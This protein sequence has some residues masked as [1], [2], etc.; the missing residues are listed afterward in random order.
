MLI[1]LCLRA[2]VLA[3]VWPARPIERP[4]SR[5]AAQTPRAGPGARA[6]GNAVLRL[7]A[8]AGNRAVGQ[9]LR[10]PAAEKEDKPSQ[11]GA[12][13]ASSIIHD[14]LQTWYTNTH[15]GLDSAD[16]SGNSDGRKWFIIALAGNLLWA[17]TAFLDPLVLAGAL[18][19]KLMSVSGATIGSGT[20][21]QLFETKPEAGLKGMIVDGLSK[22]RH[23][24][25][26]DTDLIERVDDAFERHGLTDRND[27]KQTV[28]RYEL[29]WKV[30]FGDRVPYGDAAAIEQGAKA[31][32][33]AISAHF[34][35]KYHAL[36]MFVATEESRAIHGTYLDKHYSELPGSVGGETSPAEMDE[37]NRKR[38]I[39]EAN[40]P[41]YVRGLY[42]LALVSSGVADRMGGA[43][44]HDNFI[45]TEYDFP[46]G[47]FVV[48]ERGDPSDQ[49]YDRDDPLGG[50]DIMVPDE[51]GK[52][53]PLA[54][55]TP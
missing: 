16:L 54:P 43:E 38:A 14:H 49:G 1:V 6:N 52:L 31:N 53:S 25:E 29:A 46:G 11:T 9:L 7:Q 40:W 42:Y 4:T 45:G 13:E 20:M 3:L 24:M 2:M 51:K 12:S 50:I 35:K 21:Q 37:T 22:Q 26:T 27:P 36:R 5:R 10:S 32:A 44:Q 41:R 47:A 33:E 30:M 15:F 34:W 48:L 19:I 39:F 18:A 17:A 23:V 55:V 8:M 28:G